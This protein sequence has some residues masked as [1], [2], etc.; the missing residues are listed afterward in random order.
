M[1]GV[2]DGAYDTPEGKKLTMYTG[3]ATFKV[4]LPLAVAGSMRKPVTA[5]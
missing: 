4:E 2:I 3:G 5:A 1:P